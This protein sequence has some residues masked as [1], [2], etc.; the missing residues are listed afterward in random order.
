MLLR[1]RLRA[2]TGGENVVTESRRRGVFR[3]LLGYGFKTEFPQQPAQHLTAELF[4]AVSPLAEDGP[5]QF[6]KSGRY[7]GVCL[8]G[9]IQVG[10]GQVERATAPQQ[11]R[12]VSE[13][14]TPFLWAA[15]FQQFA[16]PDLGDARRRERQFREVG[17]GIGLGA[18][19]SSY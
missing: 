3:R 18:V 12:P 16:A 9:G 17:D 10:E 5:R 13:Q 8:L 1:Q 14:A 19:C 6:P 2:G 4:A 15:V 7:L 11:P